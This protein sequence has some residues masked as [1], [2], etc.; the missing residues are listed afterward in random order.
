MYLNHLA[1]PIV[2]FTAL[3][4]GLA[5]VGFNLSKKLKLGQVRKPLAM[6]VGIAGA[7][8]LY[9]WWTFNQT[10][11]YTLNSGAWFVNSLVALCIGLAAVGFNVSK[12]LK[13]GKTREL[14]QYV[15]GL[16]GTYSLLI[17]FGILH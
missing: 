9:N 6:L 16:T 12:K 3:C 1:W 11:L 7:L 15:V 10:N 13:L 5:A 8:N 2:A 17:Y 4:V 14:L